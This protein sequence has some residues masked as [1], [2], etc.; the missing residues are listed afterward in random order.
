M[1]DVGEDIRQNLARMVFIGQ[2]VDHRNTRIFRKTL[3][4]I[5]AESANHDDVAHARHHLCGIFHRFTAAELAIAG[6]QID[7][8]TT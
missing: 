7:C 8:G 6:V 4:N 3:N 2:T 1:L 5:L